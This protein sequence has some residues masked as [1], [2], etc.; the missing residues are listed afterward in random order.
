M[1][2]LQELVRLHRLGDGAREVARKLGISPNTE[3]EYRMALA[4]A[5]L[6]E[7]A[8][9]ALPE[10][11]VLR[12][13]VDAHKPSRSP[14][15]QESS[16]ERWRERIETMMNDG[17]PPTAIYD[18]L[19]VD[20]AEFEGSLSAVKRMYASLRKAKGVEP[21]DVAIPVETLPGKVAQVDFGSV[22]KLWDPREKRVRKA[23]V[24]VMVL[25]HSRH[26]FARLV[27]D[28]KIETW[29]ALH[30]EA[31]AWFGGVP[32]VMV[33]DNLKA[34][35]IRAA[36]DVKTEPVLNRSYRELAR[37]YSF[38]I[39]PTPA[40]SPEKKGK[41]E[42]GV[43]YFKGN[44]MKT[45][46]DE[47]DI[48]VLNAMVDRWVCEIAGTRP[49][50]TTSR[51]PLEHFEATERDVLQALPVA[52]WEPVWWR[53]PTLHRDCCGLVEMA[54]YSAP[55]R[56]VGKQLLARVTDKSVELYWEDTRVATH[57]RQPPGGRSVKAEHLPP[58]RGEYR[59]RERG[60]WVERAEK[61]GGDVH[62]YVIEVFG[63]DDVLSQLT[64]VQSIIRHLETFPPERANAACRRASYFGSYSYA[65][66][67]NILRKGLDLDPL[68]QLMVPQHGA[69]ERPRFARNVQEILDLTPKDNDAPH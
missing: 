62:R 53:E 4:L 51:R 66:I 50:G 11:A 59:E 42:A 24:F 20:E 39:D 33:P 56:L 61:L 31:F 16:V 3:R 36:F 23:Y 64:K 45:I 2:R 60:Y 40:Y 32:E 52:K 28:Q 41:V 10:L 9:E 55:W 15:Q 69:L 63:S 65:A 17:A 46:G 29:L 34:A 58:E 25:G 12:A 67:K 38:K 48:D 30:V 44:F 7:G 13:A 35:V 68:P 1:H 5:G 14:P 54:R 43:R 37:H 21:G 47:R 27:F 18:R 8:P 22:G 49:H 19:R 6:L 57:E 26:Q